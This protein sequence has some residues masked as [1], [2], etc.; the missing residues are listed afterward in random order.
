[1]RCAQTHTHVVRVCAC[2]CVCVCVCVYV[3]V[4]VCVCVIVQIVVLP[5]D[6]SSASEKALS[7]ILSYF[8]SPLF[9]HKS[10]VFNKHV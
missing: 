9:S 10:D 8:C 4:C 7:V 5:H 6:I 1:M 3:Y 2:A